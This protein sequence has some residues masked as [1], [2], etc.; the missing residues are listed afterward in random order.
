[1]HQGGLSDFGLTQNHLQFAQMDQVTCRIF[2]SEFSIGSIESFKISFREKVDACVKFYFIEQNTFWT[3]LTWP[4]MKCGGPYT[5]GYY[6]FVLMYLF[7]SLSISSDAEDE[8][9]LSFTFLSYLS[10]SRLPF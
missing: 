4:T 7:F 10:F 8:G 2:R 6:L 9:E 1:M 3:K 5:T